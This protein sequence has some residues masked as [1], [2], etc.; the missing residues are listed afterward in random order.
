MRKSV[1]L[2][3]ASAAACVA[4]PA[5]AASNVVAEIGQ[6]ADVMKRGGYSVEVKKED[7]TDY[8]RAK[9]GKDNYTFSVFFNGCAEGTMRDCKSVQFYSGFT[10]KS[11]PGL[12]AMNAYARDNRWGRV[13]LDKDGDP[14]IEMDVDLE[15]GGM[16][17]VL[18]L[19]NIEYFEAVLD[20]FGEFAFTGKATD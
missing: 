2:L 9:R 10:P 3:I 11:K 16:P 13:Y 7:G 1:G 15:K 19:D 20:R 6:V 14:V 12:E 8:I 4:S 18:F 17:E 5:V